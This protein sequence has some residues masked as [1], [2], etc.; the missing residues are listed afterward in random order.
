MKIW[1][2]RPESDG[3]RSPLLLINALRHPIIRKTVARGNKAVFFCH[4]HQKRDANVITPVKGILQ[5][6]HRIASFFVITDKAGVAAD[7]A[8]LIGDFLKTDKVGGPGNTLYSVRSL[9]VGI[10]DFGKDAVQ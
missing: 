4:I 1:H 2:I 5:H 6:Y 8:D 10:P 7:I 3:G 9:N